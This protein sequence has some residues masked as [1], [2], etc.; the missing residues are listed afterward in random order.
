MRFSMK[1]VLTF[2]CVVGLVT[3]SQATAQTT[4]DHD[5]AAPITVAGVAGDL[6]TEGGPFPAAPVVAI[7]AAA[8]GLVPGDEID[9]L[10]FGDDIAIAGFHALAFSVDPAAVGIPATGVDFEVTMDTAPG[11]FGVGPR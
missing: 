6:L 10:S 1:E 8:I 4:F 5:H 11:V 9:A 7:G 3:A 2:S